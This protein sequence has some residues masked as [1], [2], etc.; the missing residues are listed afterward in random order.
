VNN[1]ILR[2]GNATK[3]CEDVVIGYKLYNSGFPVA[4]E[5][6]GCAAF[7]EVW[8]IGDNKDTLR[9]L[10]MLEGEGRMYHRTT[11][12]TEGGHFVDMYVGHDDFWSFRRMTECS[13]EDEGDG[14]LYYEWS[15]PPRVRDIGTLIDS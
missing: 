1:Y 2:E 3:V 10:D 14:I 5:C 7:G 15:R 9:R 4:A 11:V 6:E 8:D 12:Q 13:C